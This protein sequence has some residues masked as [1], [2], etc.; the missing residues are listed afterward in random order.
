MNSIREIFNFVD[1]DGSG[2]V[3][4]EEANFLFEKL[5][6]SADETNAIWNEMDKDHSG[7]IEFEEFVILGKLLLDNGVTAAELLR[8]APE[9]PKLEEFYTSEQLAQIRTIFGISFTYSYTYS[10]DMV[11]T[12]GSGAIDIDELAAAMRQF[13]KAFTAE[14]TEQ[15]FIKLDED[16]DGSISFEEFVKGTI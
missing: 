11:D 1:S 9:K 3:S 16:K 4:K 8:E 14:Q 10:Q 13:G 12:D 5:Q 2:K 15:L 7:S 6:V